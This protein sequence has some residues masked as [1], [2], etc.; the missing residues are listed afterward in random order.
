MTP[1]KDFVTSGRYNSIDEVPEEE[2]DDEF[3]ELTHSQR[4]LIIPLPLPSFSSNSPLTSPDSELSPPIKFLD[5]AHLPSPRMLQILKRQHPPLTV[6]G[7]ND[8]QPWSE[9]RANL[10][11]NDLYSH[12]LGS[13]SRSSR[14][15]RMNLRTSVSVD[16]FFPHSSSSFRSP[17]SEIGDRESEITNRS[18]CCQCLRG[19]GVVMLT[20]GL[21]LAI[22]SI[23][24]FF[25]AHKL[26]GYEGQDAFTLITERP[27]VTLPTWFCCS[28]AMMGVLY[29]V[30]L[31]VQH[32]RRRYKERMTSLEE[33]VLF[34]SETMPGYDGTRSSAP[35]HI[36][37][38]FL[39]ILRQF[40]QPS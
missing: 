39:D 22:T 37:L 36:R 11:E 31:G 19:F 40:R 8:E 34:A 12:G 28:F 24:S 20:L 2:E 13:H 16:T 10:S 5:P 23:P 25:L 21:A 38:G 9:Y 30:F 4:R 32:L 27:D 6:V 1:A 14:S 33:A 17:Y 15:S 3:D 35:H 18:R 26:V 7:N 29:V